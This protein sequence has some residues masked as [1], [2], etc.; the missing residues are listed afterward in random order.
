MF[1][2]ILVPHDGSELSQKAAEAA[3]QFAKSIGAKI[4]VFYAQEQPR[5]SDFRLNAQQM[6]P[7]EFRA[8][9]ERRAKAIAE[10]VQGIAKAAGVTFASASLAASSPYEAIVKGARDNACDLIFMA[11]HGRKG[12]SAL[13]IGSET[14][15][16]LTHCTIPVMVY[17]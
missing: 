14:Y 3:V 1:K 5:P 6:P 7:E 16:V 13:V 4:T 8:D 2:H 17:R 11:S 10:A 12:F 9:E 15:K